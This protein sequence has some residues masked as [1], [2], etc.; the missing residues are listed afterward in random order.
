MIVAFTMPKRDSV[1]IVNLPLMVGFKPIEAFDNGSPWS[2]HA[3]V[4]TI[5]RHCSTVGLIILGNY[6]P[7][8]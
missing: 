6:D 3:V 2:L 5:G 4:F 8:P 7:F 1:T